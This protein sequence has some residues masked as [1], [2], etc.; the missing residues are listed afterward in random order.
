MMTEPGRRLPQH[1]RA[2]LREP[3]PQS[4]MGDRPRPSPGAEG[5]CSWE[6]TAPGRVLTRPVWAGSSSRR[7]PDHADPTQSTRLPPGAEAGAHDRR[8]GRRGPDRPRV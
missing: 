3:R 8:P 6:A 5:R 1:R 4:C 7:H 2:C